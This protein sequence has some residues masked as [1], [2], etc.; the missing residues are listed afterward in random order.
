MCIRLNNLISFN[1]EAAMVFA[2]LRMVIIANQ[3]STS[4]PVRAPPAC[5]AALPPSRNSMWRLITPSPQLHAPAGHPE[6]FEFNEF[7]PAF[8]KILPPNIRAAYPFPER[9]KSLVGDSCGYTSNSLLASV[10]G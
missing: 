8:L 9:R 4:Q 1:I 2:E 5:V 7:D 3:T 10:W 6:P